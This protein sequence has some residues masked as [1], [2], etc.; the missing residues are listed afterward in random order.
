MFSVL[1]FEF[2]CIFDAY[3]CLYGL[4]LVILANLLLTLSILSLEVTVQGSRLNFKC[5][6]FKAHLEA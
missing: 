5:F 2:C 4:Y 6:T 1:S 3:M